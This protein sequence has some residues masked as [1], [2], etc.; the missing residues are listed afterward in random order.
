MQAVATV[1]HGNRDD[2]DDAL[3]RIAPEHLTTTVQWNTQV[4]DAPLQMQLTSELVGA[5][6]HV[7]ALQNEASTAGYGLFHISGLLALFDNAHTNPYL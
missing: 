1:Q 2:I 4:F 7:S 3:F 5:Q 6:N